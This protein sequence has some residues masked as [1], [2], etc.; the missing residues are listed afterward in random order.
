MFIL[1]LIMV[2]RGKKV[3]VTGAD[4]FIGSHLTEALVRE[5]ASVRAL[6]LYNS[7]NSW[8]WLDSLEADVR[9]KL[10]VVASDIRDPRGMEEAV[11]DCDAVFHL[12]ALIAIPFSYKAPDSFVDTNIRGTLNILNACRSAGTERILMTSTSEVYGTAKFIPITEEHPLQPQSPYSATKIAADSLAEAYWRT[13]DMPITLVRP[14]NTYGP[15]QSARAFIP[16][17]ITQLLSA[18]TELKLGRIDPVRD[19]TFVE[20][21]ARGF[22][23]LAK[24][25]DAK[26][27]VVNI[28]TEEGHSVKKVTEQLMLI[29]GR[30]VPIVTDEARIR[31]KDSEVERLVGSA[32]LLRSLT[33]WKP[34]VTFAEGLE[35]T[36]AWYKNSENLKHYKPN[37]YTL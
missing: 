4:G 8:G 22:I 14:F 19:L 26:K 7:F 33:P 36:V 23:E 31:P 29:I 16:T 21:T 37:E 12:A 35:K 10:E 2:L 17:V 1:V 18:A 27:R 9:S 32:E 15:R 24:C 28:A 25:D 5:G 11:R 6:V 20:D 30:K 3:L 13:Y 34:S